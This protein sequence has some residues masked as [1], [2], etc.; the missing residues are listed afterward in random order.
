MPGCRRQGPRYLMTIPLRPSDFHAD[1]LVAGAGPAGVALAMRLK[2]LAYDVVLAVAPPANAAHEFE[3]LN[4]AAQEQLAFEGLSA[5]HGV[6][7]EFEIRWGPGDFERRAQPSMSLLVDRRAFHA[8]LRRSAE[9]AGIRMLDGRAEAPEKGADGWCMRVGER[10]ASARLLVDATGRR[11]IAPAARRRG[12]PLIGLHASWVGEQLP[13]SVRVAAAR[14]GWVWGAPKPD[15][16]YTTSVFQDGRFAK[17]GQDRTPWIRRIVA[18]SGIF[19]DAVHPELAGDVAASNATMHVAFAQ[20]RLSLFRIGD[21]ALALDPMSSSGIQAA[22]QSAVDAA[23][24]IHTL[25]DDLRA[26]VMVESFM[27]RRLER[28]AAR[29]AALVAAFYGEAAKAFGT[30]FWTARAGAS[31]SSEPLPPPA[32]DQPIGLGPGVRLQDEPCPVGDRIAMRRVVALPGAVEPVAIVDGVEIA[33]LFASVWP[34]AT[35]LDV[36]RKWSGVI[37]EISAVRLFEWA[38]RAGL[39]A[40]EE[41]KLLGCDER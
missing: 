19:K 18:E 1:I 28:R 16:G 24:V 34:G 2:R 5:G 7:A 30:P 25:S 41:R 10:E 27:E 20:E 6:A 35:V 38:W 33:A 22:L 3:M 4:P 12:P 23:L 9:E 37:G 21:A 17:A 40:P 11:G 13:R 8:R 31:A 14:D 36:L 29:H 32:P 39:L 26:D 15:G